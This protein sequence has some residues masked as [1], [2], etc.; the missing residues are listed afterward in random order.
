[1]ACFIYLAQVRHRLAW[2]GVRI[3]QVVEHFNEITD[4]TTKYEYNAADELVRVVDTNGNETTIAYDS[5]GHK[6]SMSDADLGDWRYTYDKNGNPKTQTDALS[7]TITFGY[8]ELNRLISKTY[9]ANDPTV[10]Y[11]YDDPTV[12]YSVGRL[13]SVS[14]LVARTDYRVFDPMGRVLE[15]RKTIIV[16]VSSQPI[17][18]MI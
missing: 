15:E 18:P 16:R 6:K 7:Q 17:R 3:V 2:R 5:L 11:G 14:N 10:E 4:Y 8:D 9:S 1:M 12:P 13:T